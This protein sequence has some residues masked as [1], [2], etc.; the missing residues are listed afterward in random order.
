MTIK[1]RF[2]YIFIVL[3]PLL[4]L[5]KLSSTSVLGQETASETV[6][7]TVKISVCG[8]GVAEYPED[9]DGMDLDGKTCVTLGHTGG[10]LSCDIACDFNTLNCTDISDST[11]S[12]DDDDDDDDDD[13]SDSEDTTIISP[14]TH[15]PPS[16][17]IAPSIPLA[18][19]FFDLDKNGKIEPA[20]AF[21]AVKLW[22][23]A[24]R[25]ALIEE[26]HVAEG[27]LFEERGIRTCDVNNDGRCDVID[28]SILLSYIV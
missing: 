8:D 13:S 22:V 16:I 17:P 7:T 6:S 3:L 25:G 1:K 5:V 11:D 24:W 12:D 19:D 20:E 14:I 4:V 23:G 9:C 21:G 28:F 10:T 15:I 27:S 2:I 18:L 26:S